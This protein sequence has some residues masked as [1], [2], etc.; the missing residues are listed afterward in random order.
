MSR[1][2]QREGFDVEV[3]IRLLETDVDSIFGAIRD[4]QTE[5]VDIEKKQQERY[6]KIMG[7]INAILVAFTTTAG[8]LA[9]NIVY[10]FVVGP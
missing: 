1:A 7:R 8:M 4:V 6:D 2:E 5:L 3:R 9:A 10:N